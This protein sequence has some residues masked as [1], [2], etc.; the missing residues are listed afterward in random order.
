MGYLT[1][2]PDTSN[3]I[4]SKREG[5]PWLEENEFEDKYSLALAGKIQKCD[6]CGRPIRLKYLE[7]GLCPDC[8][9]ATETPI[10]RNPSE[11]REEKDRCIGCSGDSD[12]D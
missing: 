12:G 1:R 2:K 6:E 9:G 3:E 10:S 11:S 5:N 8:R 7:D 4:P